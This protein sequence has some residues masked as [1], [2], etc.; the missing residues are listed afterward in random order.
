LESINLFKLKT[1]HFAHE[2]KFMSKVFY[3]CYPSER[4]DP[5]FYEIPAFAGM[6]LGR[7]ITD[8]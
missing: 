5:G 7:E 1:I 6:T 2:R 3:T 8:E 4:W